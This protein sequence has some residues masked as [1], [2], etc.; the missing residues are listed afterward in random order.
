MVPSSLVRR[1]W[2][3]ATCW[4]VNFCFCLLWFNILAT[5][6]CECMPYLY[7]LVQL[8]AVYLYCWSN[9]CDSR[10]KWASSANQRLLQSVF[11]IFCVPVLGLLCLTGPM[12]TDE[13]HGQ[14]FWLEEGADGELWAAG[15]Q[16]LLEA[17]CCSLPKSFQVMLKTHAKIHEAPHENFNQFFQHCAGK[18]CCLLPG[19]AGSRPPQCHHQCRR[20]SGGALWGKLGAGVMGEVRLVSKWGKVV[21]V[22][23]SMP[24]P[25][26]CWRKVGSS[27]LWQGSTWK[28][29]WTFRL[30]QPKRLFL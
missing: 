19:H 21:A 22:K 25:C 18:H 27:A 10:T 16:M 13:E 3:V 29:S 9:D 2:K 15:W 20:W 24:A 26:Y 7:L 1:R 8:L 5:D 17:G 12:L 23:S 4:A 14:E 28:S 6:L 11:R 30:H